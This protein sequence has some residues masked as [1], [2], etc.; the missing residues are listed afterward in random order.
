MAIAEAVAKK[1]LGGERLSREEGVA[2]LRDGDFLELG[3]LADSVRRRLHPEGIVTYIIDRNI[4]YTNVCTAQCA[5]CAFY[6]DLPSKEGYLLSKEQLAR[7]IEETLALGGNQ[8]LLQGGLHPDLGIE[9]Y[10]ELFRW[11]KSTYPIWI[12]GL[13]PAEIKHIDRVSN[14]TTE[15]TLRRLIAAGLDSIPGGG[16]EVLSDRVRQI[17]GIAKGSTADWLDVM[18][19]AHRLG[20]RTT[21]TMMFGHVETLEERID[22]LLHLRDLQDRTGGFTAFIA[23]TFQPTNTAMAGDELTSFQYLRTLAVARVMLDNFPSVQA[24]WVTQGGKIGQVSLRFGANDFGSLMI[25]ENVVSAAGAHFRL[26]EAEIARNIQDA[27]FV[28]KR[29]TMHYEIVGD[30]Y[31]WTHTVPPMPAEKAPATSLAS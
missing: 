9:F 28:P 11:M 30:P 16:A 29:R 6:R 24:S 13:S 3:M 20:L 15:Q 5:F 18:E 17:I 8:I 23:W 14:L 7:K 10:E 27:G 12:H 22:H 21:A 2:L 26:T 25:E 19:T 31:C 1:V 4:N